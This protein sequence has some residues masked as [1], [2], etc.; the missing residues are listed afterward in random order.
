[1]T[2]S[3]LV[4]L[5]ALIP[6]GGAEA[7]P[8]VHAQVRVDQVGY[9][10]NATKRAYLM[11]SAARPGVV[12]RVVSSRGVTVYTSTVG[13][14]KGSWSASYPDVY[15]MDFNAVHAAGSYH[16]VVSDGSMYAR[17]PRFQVDE[18]GAAVRDR[19]DE[20]AVVLSERA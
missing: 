8:A 15:A 2:A 9:A 4:T 3:V 16:I 7:A 1:M 19:D 20:L 12:F 17:S 10:T 5:P 14:D 13:A 18:P 11:T 6:A